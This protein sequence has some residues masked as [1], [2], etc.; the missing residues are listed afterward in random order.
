MNEQL[1][2]EELSQVIDHEREDQI[3]QLHEQLTQKEEEARNNKA[4]S[5]ILND[6][7]SKGEVKLEEDGSI[8][9]VHRPNVIGNMNDEAE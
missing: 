7:L 4:A 6:L 1:E 8:K 2:M 9:V 3:K 5:D